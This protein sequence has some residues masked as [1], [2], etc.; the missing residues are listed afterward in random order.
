M[1]LVT[2]SDSDDEHVHPLKKRKTSNATTINALPPLPSTFHDLY[3]STA[4][5]STSDDP[6]L[7]GG[8]RR[9]VPHVEGN[10][11]THVYFEWHPSQT[12]HKLLSSLLSTV[13]AQAEASDPHVTGHPAATQKVHSLLQSELGVPSPLHVSLSRPLVFR[14]ET[15]DTFLERV[16]A[17]IA[18]ADVRPFAVNPTELVWHGNEDMTRWFLVLRVAKPDGDD[19]RKLLEACNKVVVGM[20]QP[21]LYAEENAAERKAKTTTQERTRPR[22]AENAGNP[23]AADAFHISIAWSLHPPPPPSTD[24]E[25]G[26]TPLG[27]VTETAMN[28]VRKLRISFSEVKLKI[29]RDVRVLPLNAKKAEGRSILG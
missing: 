17:A 26:V 7:H 11:P 15:K 21:A 20:G 29:G 6:S 14:T 22:E 13:Q 1:T 28:E 9:V 27:E 19:M 12:E 18:R 25:A 10:W 8:R 5:V 16:T 24:S 4:R 3:S 2:Y 23:K